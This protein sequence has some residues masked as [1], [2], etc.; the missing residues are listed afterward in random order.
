MAYAFPNKTPNDLNYG[1]IAVGNVYSFE[2][3]VDKDLVDRFADLS[4]DYNPLHMDEKY[5]AVRSSGGRIVH[6]MLL[7][8]FFSASVGM[9][10]PGR[11]ALYL[12]Q[13]LH[14]RNPVNV[15]QRVVIR[16][17]VTAKSDAGRVITLAMEI[18]DEK[19]S[20]CVDGEAKVK[21]L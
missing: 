19:G 20:V 7:A 1:E 11:R 4:G 6:G 21:I 8:S 15:G 18:C 10:C 17:T 12:S 2:R 16:G 5:A 9:V 14:F 3:V 13:E